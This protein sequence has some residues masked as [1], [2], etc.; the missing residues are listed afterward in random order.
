MKRFLFLF[1]A[2]V[3]LWAFFL[4]GCGGPAY[5]NENFTI[6]NYSYMLVIDGSQNVDRCAMVTFTQKYFT[7]KG[8]KIIS[9]EERDTMD[10]QESG[11]ALTCVLKFVRNTPV[12]TAVVELYDIAGEMQ[13]QGYGESDDWGR[14]EDITEAFE[15]ALG[16]I[17]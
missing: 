15:S 11:K 12:S 16:Y 6:E 10:P 3:M 8:L 13:F 2:A 17:P 14:C 1:T 4:Q 7:D 9:E 5:V